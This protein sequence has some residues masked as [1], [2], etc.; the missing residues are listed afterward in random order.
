MSWLT[1]YNARFPDRAESWPGM[2][3][4]RKAAGFCRS[5]SNDND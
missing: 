2:R 3:G 5:F 1:S 4:C